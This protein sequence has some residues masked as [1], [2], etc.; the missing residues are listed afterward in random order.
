MN[1]SKQLLE[2]ANLNPTKNSR[3][4]YIFTL[5]EYIEKNE[6][7]LPL[8]QRDISW[9]LTKCVE[10]LN[11]QLL[12]KSPISAISI[13]IINNT[14]KEYAVPQVSFIERELLAEPVRGQMSVV[15]G[16]QRLTTNYKAYIDS[17]DFKSIVLD[18][19]KGKFVYIGDNTFPQ[20]NQ[21]PVGILLNK[22]GKKLTEYLKTHKSLAVFEVQDILVKVRNKFK[23]YYYTINKA[24]DLSE[25]EQIRWFEVLNN[26]G[27]RVSA[28]QMGLSKLRM[29]GIDVYTQYT[30]VFVEKL[31]EHG[32]E[33]VFD[34]ETTKHT[35][36]ICALNAAYEVIMGTPHSNNYCPMASDVR[37]NAICSMK[38]SQILLSFKYTLDALDKVID[39]IENND[40]DIPSRIDYINFLIGYFVFY[41]REDKVDEQFLINWYNTVNFSN[42]S[43][44]ERRKIYSKLLSKTL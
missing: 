25:E 16:Q 44:T 39:F 28:V 5:C 19:C 26:A 4:E 30:H 3:Q 20:N 17:E 1:I 9:T 35:Y 14:D 43:N 33:S 37:V 40:L 41:Q 15:D 18:L 38:A 36:P 42:S 27:S 31:K 11:Y 29:Y 32:F 2:A 8:Y 10:L 34:K 22:D 7:T 23:S 6:L 13:N 21:I 24:H 12:S